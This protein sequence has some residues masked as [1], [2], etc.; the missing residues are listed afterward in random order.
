MNGKAG[1]LSLVSD[2]IRAGEAA[3]YNCK[4]VNLCK[5]E[6]EAKTTNKAYAPVC[7][8]AGSQWSRYLVTLTH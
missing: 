5:G 3:L 4:N 1:R 8:C 6:V 7:A 2:N